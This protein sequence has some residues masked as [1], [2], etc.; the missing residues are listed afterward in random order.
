MWST[1]LCPIK[2]GTASEQ[3]TSAFWQSRHLEMSSCVFSSLMSPQITLTPWIGAISSRSTA[4][5]LSLPTQVECTCSEMICAHPPGA[6]P[7]STT[8]MPGLNKSQ[9]V[10][11]SISLKADLDLYFYSFAY[12]TQWSL[13]CLSIQSRALPRNLLLVLGANPAGCLPYFYV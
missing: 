8:F 9:R 1:N 4:T 13:T 10:L 5:T 11:I 6:A 2:S 3:T 12:L 7:T